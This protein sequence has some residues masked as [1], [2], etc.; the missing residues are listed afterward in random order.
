MQK[1]SGNRLRYQIGAL[2]AASLIAHMV[3]LVLG[4]GPLATWRWPHEAIHAS[5]EMIGSVAAL[6]CAWMLSWLNRRQAGTSFNIHIAAAMCGMG[7]LDGCHALCQPG[8]NF[9][10]L[11]STSTFL[12]GL[13]FCLIGTDKLWSPRSSWPIVVSGASLIF[14]LLS[15]V[16]PEWV[17]S[18]VEQGQFTLTAIVLNLLGGTMMLFAGALLA[19]SHFARGNDDDLLFCIHCVLFGLAAIMF[20]QSALW[21]VPWWGWHFLRLAAYGVAVLFIV[22]NNP[23]RDLRRLVNQVQLQKETLE[24]AVA[25]RTS[26]LLKLNES[27]RESEFRALA[28]SHAKTEFLANMSHEIRTPM[29][30]IMGYAE[31]LLEDE[32]LSKASPERVE[33]LQSIDRNGKHLLSI[34]NDILDMSKI[35]AGRMEV[36]LIATEPLEIANEVVELLKERAERKKLKIGVRCET[37]FP[38]TIFT[39][40]LRIRQIL[41]NI[42][43]NAVKFT[44]AGRVEI[45]LS[46]AKSPSKLV[47]K[48]VDTGI[49]M[50]EEKRL[51]MS[52]FEAFSQA[53]TSMSRNF[54][55][56]GLGLRISNSLAKI[57][58]GEITIESTLGKGSTFTVAV[59]TGDVSEVPL[60]RSAA[61]EQKQDRVPA[62]RCNIVRPLAGVRLLL[63]EDGIDNQRI[64]SK[65]MELSGAEVSVVENGQ[66][67]VEAAIEGVESG[68][69]FDTILMDM[70]MPVMDGYTAVRTLRD[71]DYTA[72]II[73]LTAHA[74]DHDRDICLHAGCDDFQTKPVHREKLVRAILTQIESY[75]GELQP[76]T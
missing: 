14:A 22:I 59:A 54:G 31:L 26:E 13:L 15:C 47:F 63:A 71:R 52:R 33:A 5:V 41:L 61:E 18:M 3:L 35:E 60:V 8:N 7:I 29:T 21:D 17:P 24:Q 58:G 28:A 73:A 34:I 4:N 2:L 62:E 23:E 65:I 25:S 55:G 69:P 42:V 39:D 6:W 49:G 44:Q 12:G 36:E 56:T 32:E 72:P 16:W 48:V 57:L 70:Q 9:V 64:I 46:Y 45:C 19:G 53:D 1:M 38:Q 50:S 66:L 68:R 40:P 75:R 37:P 10:W 51:K 20:Q 43:G 67:A 30:A 27:L 74:M 76:S 11:H